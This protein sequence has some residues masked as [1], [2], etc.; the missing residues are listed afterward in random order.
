MKECNPMATITGETLQIDQL[1]AETK[2]LTPMNMI[3]TGS[4]ADFDQPDAGQERF[5]RENT[6]REAERHWTCCILHSSGSTGFPRAIHIPHRRLMIPIPPSPEQLEYNTFPM[7]HGYGNWI[8]VHNC[9]N[10]K[11]TYMYNSNRHLTADYI[12]EVV[13]HVKPQVLHVVPYTLELLASSERGVQAMKSCLRVVFSGSGCPDDLGDSL[14]EKGV[15]IESMWGAT[16]MGFLGS[17]SNRPP[18]DI[19]WNFIRIPK[20][21]NDHIWFKHVEDD[22]YECIYLNSLP[23]LVASNSDDP[24]GSFWSNDLFQKHPTIPNA[25][26]HIGRLDDTLTLAN[27]EK[28][29]PLPMEGRIRQDSLIRE[30]VVFGTG[31][32]IPGVL[33][34]KNDDSKTLSDREFIDGIWPTIQA[35]N[36]HAESFSQISKETIIPMG[37]DVDYPKTDK[38]SIKRAQVYIKFSKE[39]EAMYDKLTYHGTGTMRLDIPRMEDWLLHTFNSQIGVP[40]SSINDDFFAAGVN[41]LHA[42]QMRGLILKDI[43]LGGHASRLGQNVIFDMGTVACLAR[44]IRSLQL[45]EEILDDGKDEI[46]DMVSL[47]KRYSSFK[48][49][50]A[51]SKQLDGKVLLLTGVTGSLGAEILAQCLRN[52][53]IRHVYCLVRGSK[54]TDRVLLALKQRNLSIPSLVQFTALTADISDPFLGL[55]TECY[56]S[57][58]SC[59]THVVHS[60][61]TVNFNLGLRSFESQHL[62][63]IHN[64]LQ[65]TLSSPFSK[66]AQ[67]CFCSSIAVALATPVP[68]TVPEGPIENLAHALPHGYARSKLVAEHIIHGASQK[69]GA[70]TKIFRIGQIVGE[71]KTGLWNDAEVIPLIIRSALTLNALPG[72]NQTESWLPVDTLANSIC[73]LSGLSGNSQATEEKLDPENDF[74]YNIENPSTFRWTE[75]LLP[76]L[77]RLGLQ[78]ETIPPLAWLEKLR[79]YNGDV[80]ANPAVKLLGHFEK[81][82]AKSGIV[83]SQGENKACVKFDLTKVQRESESLRTA[84]KIIQDGYMEKFVE[85]WTD[86]WKGQS[87]DYILESSG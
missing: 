17:S 46:Q 10:R 13:K 28:V 39:I 31:R 32:S 27:G 57:L 19:Y 65:L 36:A 29:I 84:P 80:E 61:W 62:A 37:A 51:G 76:E 83:Q 35:A 16:E 4:R 21:I 22:K 7:F 47:I 5:A 64:L 38:E 72:L 25:W 68:A 85:A 73:E 20:P 45:G 50:I 40:I 77:A 9:R 12:I 69:Y 24:P 52:P 6:D 33:I 55:S 58:Q 18:G 59:V 54:P 63:G 71:K 79:L 15:N 86:K 66:P 60:A 30:G 78:F 14:I 81:I 11:S 74:I 42:V 34:F 23:S 87:K 53:S 1:V 56:A 43:D 41:S 8:I 75:D 44:Y 48:K 3:K 67:F 2:K 26:K 82:Y 70:R 49:H